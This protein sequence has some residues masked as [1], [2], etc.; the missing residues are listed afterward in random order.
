MKGF[1]GGVRCVL[2]L[3]V[4]GQRRFEDGLESASQMIWTIIPR[5]KAIK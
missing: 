3:G 2:S 1:Q 5:K 4:L